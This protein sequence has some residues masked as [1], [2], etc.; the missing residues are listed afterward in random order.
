MALRSAYAASTIGSVVI[1]VSAGTSH[2]APLLLGCAM[3]GSANAAAMLS[4]YASADLVEARD[5]GRAMSTMMLALTVGAV[6]APNLLGPA[7]VLARLAGAPPVTGIFI[8]AAAALLAALVCL[9]PVPGA[10]KADPLGHQLVRGRDGHRARTMWGCAAGPAAVLASANLV[11]VTVMAVV[12]PALHAH[13][14]SLHHLGL[15]VS[16]HV[17]A[18]F[19]PSVLVGRI[20]DR[21]GA[22]RVALVGTWFTAS[23]AAG[24]AAAAA[25]SPS[26]Q[27]F[28]MVLLGSAW[29]VQVVAGSAWL[30]EETAQANRSFV[31]GIGEAWMAVAAVVGTLLAGPL[32]A[33]GGSLVLHAGLAALAALAACGATKHGSS[34]G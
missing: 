22:R 32:L 5:R 25:S 16:A 33:A 8:V 26:T 4:R 30:L 20:A 23:L 12:P 7:S 15:I 2:M 28:F 13:G 24:G 11:M 14:A 1:V 9:P 17:L 6:V 29:C 18:M 21:V 10:P 31:E 27:A 19:A 3:F 34:R